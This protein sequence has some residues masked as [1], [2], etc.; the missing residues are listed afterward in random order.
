MPGSVPCRP[1]GEGRTPRRTRPARPEPGPPGSRSGR[2]HR[3]GF[4][5]FLFA[6]AT[7]LAHAPDLGEALRQVHQHV[8]RILADLLCRGRAA[9][10]VR[11]DIDAGTAAWWLVSL[12]AGRS[13]RAAVVP[14]RERVEAEL[15]EP[16][17][18]SLRPARGE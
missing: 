18:R 10:D 9:G 8:A 15:T 1:G 5:G 4:R 2:F 16:A 17:L 3:P 11:T 14:D 12:L 7:A 6:D 13:F